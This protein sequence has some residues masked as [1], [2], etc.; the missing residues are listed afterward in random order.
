MI[1]N[2]SMANKEQ[3]APWL[4]VF[5]S[6]KSLFNRYEGLK[7]VS[8][9]G[10]DDYAC[11]PVKL[12]GGNLVTNLLFYNCANNHIFSLPDISELTAISSLHFSN[13]GYYGFSLPNTQ[14]EL[15]LLSS[16]TSLTITNCGVVGGINKNQISLIFSAL[17]KAG[18]YNGNITIDQ[19]IKFIP[20]ID[21]EAIGVLQN[22]IN[23]GWT[24]S[25]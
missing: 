14:Q 7:N 20:G 8:V 15:G 6:N 9:D 24:I 2:K 4:S 5:N 19:D 11:D 23:K 1:A 13:C 10:M 22:L 18:N 12:S 25:I 16:L 17:D 3:G 21:D